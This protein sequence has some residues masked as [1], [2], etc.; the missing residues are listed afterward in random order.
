MKAIIILAIVIIILVLDVVMLY[1]CVRINYIVDE[2]LRRRKC[3]VKE[4]DSKKRSE[5]SRNEP[6]EQ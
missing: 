4:W 5:I 3:G 6:R 1:S 2:R